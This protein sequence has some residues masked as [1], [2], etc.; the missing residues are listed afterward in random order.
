MPATIRSR[1]FVLP[2]Y[3]VKAQRVKHR[4]LQFCPLFYTGVKPGLSNEEVRLRVLENRMLWKV[5][6]P[7]REEV[8]G[9]W[10]KLHNQGLHNC[11]P[12]HILLG[13]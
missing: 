10:R 8:T 13:G 11:T 6:G 3:Y 12:R 5:F 2:I 1:I 9:I 7:K 4:D